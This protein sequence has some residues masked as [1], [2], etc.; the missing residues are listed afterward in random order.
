M[1]PALVLDGVGFCFGRFGLV[2]GCDLMLGLGFLF[3]FALGW[4]VL[5]CSWF[6]WV[7]FPFG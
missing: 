5:G 4:I 6:W 1:G 3:F 2:L 7:G